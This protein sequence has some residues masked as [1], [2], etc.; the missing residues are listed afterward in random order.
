MRIPSRMGILHSYIHMFTLLCE[1][2]PAFR[3]QR[4]HTITWIDYLPCTRVPKLFFY[5]HV[6]RKKNDANKKHAS[7]KAA[8]NTRRRLPSQRVWPLEKTPVELLHRQT[9]C[10]WPENTRAI[11]IPPCQ[12]HLVPSI[13]LHLVQGRGE[14]PLDGVTWSPRLQKVLLV[15]ALFGPYMCI[16]TDTDTHAHTHT[17][18]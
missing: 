3:R 15:R 9:S 16:H 1:L 5:S 6:C 4:E 12:S 8:R 11:P 2:R 14:S 10:A 17:H 13:A 18:T 7:T